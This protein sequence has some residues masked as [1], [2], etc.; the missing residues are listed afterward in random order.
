MVMPNLERRWTAAE[1]YELPDDGIRYEVIDG[2]PFVT[3]APSLMHQRAVSLLHPLIADY[4]DRE[5]IGEAIV[6]PA[7]I[8]FPPE[9]AVQPDLFILPFVNG[10]RAR[11][12]TDVGRLLLSVEVVSPSTA[13]TDRV[14]KRVP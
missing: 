8:V 14:D 13:H 5:P 11:N 7:D 3:P 4:L 9:R 2:E 12:F 10:R 1:R 6:S